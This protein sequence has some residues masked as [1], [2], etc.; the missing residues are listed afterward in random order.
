MST[1]SSLSKA[2]GIKVGSRGLRGSLAEELAEDSPAFSGDSTV[3]LKFHGVYQQDDR[4]VRA[5]RKRARQDVD[6]ICMVRAGVPGGALSGEQYLAMDDLADRLG[7]GTLRVTTRQGIQYHFV[8]KGELADLIGALNASLVT[9]L[10]ACGD[11]VRNVCS[12]PAPLPDREA[13]G[14]A[15]LAKDLHRRT[16]PRTTAYYQLWVDGDLAVSASPPEEQDEPLYGPTYLPRKFKISI[17]WPGDNCVDAYSQ[18]VAAVPALEGGAVVGYTVLVGGGLGK[19]HTDP[20]TYP[21][22]ASSL[23]FVSPEELAEVIE[24]VVVVQRDNG[25][26]ADREHARLKYLIDSWGLDRFREAVEEQLGR[27]LAPPRDLVWES[28]DDHLGWHE[29][30]DGTWFLGVHV[31]SGRIKD[32]DGA[33]YR[34]GIRSVV[35]QVGTDVRLT[36]RQDVLL[37][38]I[39]ADHRERV[40][41]LLRE[42]GI[43]LAE[44]VAPLERSAL[45]CPALPTCGLALGEA[46]RILPDVLTA[47]ST[48]LDAAGVGDVAPHIRMTG[49]PNG[50]AR[51]YTAELG[52]VGRGKTS[53]DIH[54]GGDAAGTRMNEVFAENIPRDQ[55][56]PVLQPLLEHFREARQPGEGLGDFAAREG[57]PSLRSRFGNESFVRPARG[58]K[59]AAEN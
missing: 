19:S 42:A 50:C 45:A 2:E 52:I 12:C 17:A 14:V 43:P 15:Q 8:H 26:R 25:N 1:T 21:R 36:A 56:G 38:G 34:S 28:E 24:A 47:V 44:D 40:E 55:I 27:R 3:L 33:R 41:G 5:E 22:L 35:E 48:A 11:V 9:T 58:R 31:P 16:R 54:V 23:A 32:T 57:V 49:C 37:T 59:A 29:S 18:D 46:E 51:P 13:V 39:G 10:G 7:N 30:G 6:H 4:D 53:Y 20:T